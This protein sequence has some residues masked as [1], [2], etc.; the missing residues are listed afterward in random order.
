[1]TPMT[2]PLNRPAAAGYAVAPASDKTTVIVVYALYLAG[3]VT[4]GLS[5]VVGLVMTYVLRNEASDIARSHY[6]FLA[7][8]FWKGLVLG[9]IGWALLIVGLPL[10]LILIGIPLLIAAKLVWVAAAVWYGVR[11]VLGLMAAVD[12]RPYGRPRSW[13]I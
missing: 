4:A 6:V 7:R 3:F 11:C 13:L 10:S 8:T 1:M 5:T 9:T 2:D 12:D